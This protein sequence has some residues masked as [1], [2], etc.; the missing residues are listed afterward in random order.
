MGRGTWL[1]L[2]KLPYIIEDIS[3]W[4]IAGVVRPVPE[5]AREVHE[6]A[7][8]IF[9]L[10]PCKDCHSNLQGDRQQ[11]A[12]HS[13]TVSSLVNAYNKIAVV[14]GPVAASVSVA[15]KLAAWLSEIHSVVNASLGGTSNCAWHTDALRST[16]CFCKLCE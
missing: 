11:L 15:N 8:S 6:L 12:I 10:Y 16:Y 3:R 9:R 2:H 4:E 14:S 5:R 13:L 1:M 7:R